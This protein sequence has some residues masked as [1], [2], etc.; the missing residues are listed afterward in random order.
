[1]SEKIRSRRVSRRGVLKSAGAAAVGGASVLLGGERLAAQQGA[2]AIRTNT[3]AGRRVRA[4]V[5]L[6]RVEPPSVQTITLRGLTGRQVAIRTEAAQTCYSS[7]GQVL[8]P[9]PNAPQTAGVVGHGG[10]GIVEAVGP[11]VHAIEVGDRVIANFHNTCGWCY[12]CVR[13]RADQCMNGALEPTADLNGKPVNSG[14][15]GMTE[16]M[17]LNQEKLLPVFTDVPS[18][19]LAMLTCVGN[20][21]L[22]MTMTKVPVEAGSDVVIFGAGPV[23]LS[24][25]QGAR[26]KGAAR[27]IVVEPIRYRRELAMKLGATDVVDPHQYTQRTP[28]PGSGTNGDMFKDALVDHIRNLCKLRT[29]R[30]WATGGRIGPDHVIEAAGGDHYGDVLIK[31]SAGTGPDPSGMTVLSQCWQLVSR[32]G[33]GTSGS[34]GFPNDKRVEIEPNQFADAS[35]HW[36]SGT[37]GGTHTR[38]DVPRYVR[39]A[40]VGK[41][42]LK[43]L[44][45]RTYSLNQTREAYDVAMNRTVVATIVTPNA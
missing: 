1:M 19:E 44:A 21:G 36:W 27:I 15:S 18:V 11:E 24:A 41:L 7:V 5:K 45:S 3:Q 28:N 31:P 32:V 8:L 29:D 6:D 43:A 33:T 39:L 13:G 30:T 2:P 12:N 40:E 34:I 4:F 25:V 16:V 35:K 9:S 20:C 14:P 37:A 22:G 23:G 10:I 17:V 42:D 38:R 26:I